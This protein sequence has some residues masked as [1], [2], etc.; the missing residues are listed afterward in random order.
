MNERI[1]APSI[2]PALIP[3]FLERGSVWF[4]EN[5][6]TLAAAARTQ[7]F[8]REHLMVLEEGMEVS[9]SEVLR[10]LDELGYEKAFAAREPG[11]FSTRGGDVDIFPISSD[12]LIRLEF[13]GN[14][15]ERIA[16]GGA[17]GQDEQ[18]RANARLRRKVRTQNA[19]ADIRNLRTGDVLV[20]LDHGIGI[21]RGIREIEDKE[22][23]I[24]RPFYALEYAAG[25]N[26][27]VPLGLERKLSRYA[28]FQEPRISRLGS[29]LWEK[30]KRK[31]K[32][33]VERF[34][35][36]LLSLY[37]SRERTQRPPY[38]WDGEIWSGLSSS[39]PHEETPD[40]ERALEDI[41]SDLE[42]RSPM[43]RLVCGDVGFG[44]TEIALRT[45]AMA[46][47]NGYQAA[48]LCP[49]TLLAVQHERTF[50]ERLA[51]LP[52]RTVLLSRTQT[53][54]EEREALRAIAEGG[55]DIAIGTHRL[56]SPD[57]RFR[58]LGLLVIDDEHKFGVK[59]KEKLKEIRASLDV[60]SLSATP[61]P[62]TLSMALSS[63]RS[64]SLIHTPP[65]GRSAPT[66]TVAPFQDE[67]VRSAL[68]RELDRGGQAYILHNRVGSIERARAF[69]QGLV[70]RARIAVAHGKM[71][72]ADLLSVVAAF[73]E[74]RADILIATTIIENGLHL[75]NVN[76]LIVEDASR[77]GLAQAYQLRGRVGRS[78]RSS[79]ALFLY[80]A[81]L[82]SRAAER[83][84]ALQDA[85]LLGDGYRLAMKDLEIRG[86][87]SILGREQSGAARAV[88]LNLYCQMLAESIERVR[89]R[90][91]P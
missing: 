90:E 23:R 63:L 29:L 3:S 25:D 33:D 67:L 50:R 85:R 53:P 59:Q 78:D 24:C 57:V 26:L 14:A 54:E 37:A 42:K 8:Y 69:L 35:R 5:K 68:L 87:G 39:F 20:H 47:R 55:A 18:D 32:E 13:R 44:K 80:P 30:T 46:V 72:E 74:G 51:D 9:R 82:G 71:R 84:K 56:L 41:R 73:R 2:I 91:A 15:I 1:S 21:Y 49:T 19:Y 34:A 28:G 61:I 62:R 86:A 76:T 11:E 17:L 52:M 83:L 43:D 38:A 10:R 27:F 75:P 70:P 65:P 22:E 89:G 7:P 31:T 66:I 45:A 4:E 12:T 36:K 58:S 77:L 40:Q 81:A 48:V 16:A 6:E 60:L 88:G 79:F 64:I